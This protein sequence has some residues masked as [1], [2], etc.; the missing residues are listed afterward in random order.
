LLQ[1]SVI[2]KFIYTVFAFLGESWNDSLI[3]RFFRRCGR[4][5]GAVFSGSA[6]IGFIKREGIADRGFSNSAVYSFVDWLVN[7]P[8]RLLHPLYLRA[9]EVFAESLLFKALLFI[10][11]RLHILAAGFIFFAL[12]IEHDSWLNLYST[13]AMVALFA[14]Y[15]ARTVVEGKTGFKLSVFNAFLLLF[16]LCVLLAEIFSIMPKESLRFLAF[17]LTCFLAVMIFMVTIRSRA[18][19]SEVLFF[20]LAGVTIGGIYGVYQKYAGVAV[21]VAW[22]DTKVNQG[23][24]NRVYSFFLNPNNFAEI[25]ILFL[26][27]YMAAFFNTKSIFKKLV[28]L[29][30]ALPP[31]AALIF[32]QSRSAW[33]GFAVSVVVYLFFKEKRLIPVFILFGVIALP[34]LPQSIL[35]RLRTIT[36]V[37]DSSMAT[38]IDVYKTV[39]PILKDYWFTGLGLGNET[40]L[41]VSWNYYMFLDNNKLPSHSH[42]LYFQI[43]FETGFTGILAFLAFIGSTV[44]KSIKSL[45]GS[46]DRYVNNILIAGLASLAGILVTGLVEYVWFYQRV[47]LF[48]WVVIG[49][50]LAAFCIRE[51]QQEGQAAAE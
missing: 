42:N 37:N 28:Y 7:L 21:N 30:M 23:D 46:K 15:M 6:I 4:F 20:I 3:A 44:K 32:T 47:M 40:L 31:F 22:V 49:I 27:F 26:P 12:V 13:V 45:Y 48:F 50:M 39:L 43:W 8:Q 11:D 16:I 29:A 51:K 41:K 5:F 33:I 34:F 19:M 24:M 2:Y 18:D 9:E 14:L 36:N 10:L 38:R 35:L 1:E 25:M 17:Y